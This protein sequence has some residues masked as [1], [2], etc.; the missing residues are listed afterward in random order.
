MSSVR[1]IKGQ[2]EDLYGSRQPETVTGLT[3]EGSGIRSLRGIERFTSL[4]TL[5]LNGLRGVDLGP[6]ES[7]TSLNTLIIDRPN[8]VDFSALERLTSVEQLLIETNSEEAGK[9]VARLDFSGLTR[10]GVLQLL[11]RSPGARLP[12]DLEWVQGHACLSNLYLNGFWPLG[13]SLEEFYALVAGVEDVFILT[14][15][16]EEIARV[17]H[18]RPPRN[19]YVDTLF[20]NESGPEISEVDG[21]LYLAADLA[22]SRD[23]ETNYDAESQLRA[24]LEREAPNI[25]SRLDWDTEAD[26]VVV[27]SDD[28]QALQHV[29]EVLRADTW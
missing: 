16:R 5:A 29:C 26:Q 23:L 25:A 8:D 28:R 21:Q 4:H 2:R 14:T 18:T 12:V 7:A 10:L 3:I 17:A 27:L 22:R 19:V 1:T 6:L 24:H 9:A 20:V 11:G 15:N 13:R